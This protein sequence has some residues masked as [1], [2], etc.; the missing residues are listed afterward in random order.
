MNSLIWIVLASVLLSQVTCKPLVENKLYKEAANNK[1]RMS[2][3]N[4]SIFLY[5]MYASSYINKLVK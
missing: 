3:D 4:L 2:K 5:I 1:V